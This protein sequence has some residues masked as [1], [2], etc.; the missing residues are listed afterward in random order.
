MRREMGGIGR[1][2]GKDGKHN[3]NILCKNNILNKK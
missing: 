2:K 1:S 3:K